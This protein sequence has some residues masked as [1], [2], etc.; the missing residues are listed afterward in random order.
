MADDDPTPDI[1]ASVEAI[2]GTADVLP[3]SA[4]ASDA[5]DIAITTIDGSSVEVPRDAGDGVSVSNGDVTMTLGVP[6]AEE[7]QDA[8]TTDDGTTTFTS[9]TGG[10]STSV[11]ALEDGG[12]R[13]VYTLAEE[14]ADPEIVIPVD[15]SDGAELIQD[16]DDG[17][18][19]LYAAQEGALVPV[20]TFAT[21]WALDA[22]GTPLST[23]YTV[24]DGAIVQHVETTTATT[25]PVLADP[26]FTWGWISGTVYFNKSETRKVAYG[27]GVAS[28]IPNPY[29][30]VAGRTMVTWAGYAVASNKCIK[31]KVYAIGIIPLNLQ[32]GY[33]TGGYCR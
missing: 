20:G 27:G 8:E 13:N 31:L 18:V 4:S 9:T 3:D 25:F 33:Y 28:W 7:A 10:T 24:E 14:T 11:Q 32:P 19:S 1:G 15:L 22:D 21:P 29:I 30:V 26:Q 16:P 2:T 6:L 23:S 5:D 17:V 12:V